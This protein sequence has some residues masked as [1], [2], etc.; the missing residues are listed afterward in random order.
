MVGPFP[1]SA[2]LRILRAVRVPVNFAGPALLKFFLLKERPATE[3][4]WTWGGIEPPASSLRIN[5]ASLTVSDASG[6]KC[7]RVYSI[8]YER[9]IH[10]GQQRTRKDSTCHTC[11]GRLT[12]QNTS[13]ISAGTST[14]H[15]KPVLRT[16][17]SSSRLKCEGRYLV[18]QDFLT[19]RFGIAWVTECPRYFTGS[20][21]FEIAGNNPCYRQ[22]S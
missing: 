8:G 7:S 20:S 13:Q 5:Q 12:P 4:W 3:S 9:V 2:G 22:L 10:R 15:V 6:H 17:R 19:K 14:R 1:C 21:H 18:E 16:T 11:P